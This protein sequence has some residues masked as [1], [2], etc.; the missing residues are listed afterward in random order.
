MAILKFSSRSR[1]FANTAFFLNRIT[2]SLRLIES[3][4]ETKVKKYGKYC[5]FLLISMKQF[6]F[7]I[8]TL[9]LPCQ[10]RSLNFCRRKRLS[11]FW[12]NEHPKGDWENWSFRKTRQ[13]Q[14]VPFCNRT[15]SFERYSNGIPELAIDN[16]SNQLPSIRILIQFEDNIGLRV[17]SNVRR[18]S[19]MSSLIY[20]NVAYGCQH[21]VQNS[22][23]PK[24]TSHICVFPVTFLNL[25]LSFSLCDWYQVHLFAIEQSAMFL[26]IQHFSKHRRA[27]K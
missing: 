20:F 7:V 16:Q 5:L 3:S 24:K 23:K 14:F 19:R 4:Y 25:R 11:Q 26:T 22:Y 9:G 21:H 27:V 17:V 1:W 6:Y 2:K 15:G 12:S 18:S 13:T 8:D 10:I